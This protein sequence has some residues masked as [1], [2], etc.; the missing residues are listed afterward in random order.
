MA[1]DTTRIDFNAPTTLVER[2]DAVAELLDTTRTRILIDALREEL[3][4]LTQADEVRGVIAEAFYDGRIGFDTLEAVLG[5]EEALRMKLLRDS[6]DRAP[7]EPVVE[8]IPDAEDFYE[9]PIPEWTPNEEREDAE[10]HP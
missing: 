10:S 3:E 9:G 7:P 1:E 6:I 4:E 5:T 2:V 8:S